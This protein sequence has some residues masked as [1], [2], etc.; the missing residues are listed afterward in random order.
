MAITI[1]VNIGATDAYMNCPICLST[2]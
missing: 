2:N 1:R